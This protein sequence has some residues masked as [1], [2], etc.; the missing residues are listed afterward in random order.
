M[1][2]VLWVSTTTPSCQAPI[3]DPANKPVISVDWINV[4]SDVTHV[5]LSLLVIIVVVVIVV[6][7]PVGSRGGLDKGMLN[8]FGKKQ[9]SKWATSY[10]D[11]GRETSVSGSW[12]RSWS[13]CGGKRGGGAGS[14]R[15]PV[16]IVNWSGQ[17][18]QK[19]AI[20]HSSRL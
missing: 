12:C 5:L 15:E 11:R 8:G 7:L 6:L 20:I 4:V 1:K 10:L 2:T 9:K 18:G 13:L 17:V 3:P 19:K 16:M 14:S